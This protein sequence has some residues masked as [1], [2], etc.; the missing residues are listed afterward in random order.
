M[1]ISYAPYVAHNIAWLILLYREDNEEELFIYPDNMTASP[2]FVEIKG[3]G[4]MTLYYD[5]FIAAGMDHGLMER[6][7]N[8]ITDNC[9]KFNVILKDLVEQPV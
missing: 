6:V 7:Y 3:G 4:L 9:K 5:N 1:G 2:E 8:R